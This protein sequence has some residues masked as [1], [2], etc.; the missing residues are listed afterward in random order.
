VGQP[1][2]AA[3]AATR[4]VCVAGVPPRAARPGQLVSGKDSGLV[5]IRR[6]RV[7]AY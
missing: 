3:A 7:G 2:A 4:P 1:A 6:A 5:C